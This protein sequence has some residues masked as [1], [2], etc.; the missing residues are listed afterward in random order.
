MDAATLSP[1]YCP[2]CG[3]NL[4][5]N[6]IVTVGQLRVDPTGAAWWGDRRIATTRQH[7]RILYAL[8]KSF[9]WTLTRDVLVVAMGS[10]AEPKMVDVQVC[11]LRQRMKLADVPVG[12]IETV[13]GRGYRLDGEIAA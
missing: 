12:L 5:K 7:S 6:P 9:P 8:A 1:P 3:C 4:S 2:D 13:W 10:D 11:K